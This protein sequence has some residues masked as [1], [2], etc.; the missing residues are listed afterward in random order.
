MEVILTENVSSL[1]FVG[2][3]VAVRDGYARNYLFPHRLAVKADLR[4]KAQVA[5]RKRRIALKREGLL[6]EAA[7]MQVRLA[8]V[9]VTIRKEAGE[10]GKLYGSVTTADIADYLDKQGFAVDRKLIALEAPIKAVGTHQAA[11]KLHPELAA[12]LSIIV[13]RSEEQLG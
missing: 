9:S 4:N 12:T 3:T 8:Q 2:D 5:D 6:K 11:I 1:G 7:A 10:N 13:E